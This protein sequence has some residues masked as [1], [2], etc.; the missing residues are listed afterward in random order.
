MRYDECQTNFNLMIVEM[1][2]MP[3]LPK[4]LDLAS[5]NEIW[6]IRANVLTTTKFEVQP[7]LSLSGTKTAHVSILLIIS[8]SQLTLGFRPFATR[9]FQ[10]I[11]CWPS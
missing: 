4:R 10:Q 7:L 3:Q 6:C 2:H 5:P 8:N 9:P 11:Y 1:L